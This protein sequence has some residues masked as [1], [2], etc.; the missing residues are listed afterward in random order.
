MELGLFPADRLGMPALGV[1]EHAGRSV[2]KPRLGC[3][4]RKRFR[5]A[6]GLPG[7][8]HQKLVTFP[9]KALCN[10]RYTPETNGMIW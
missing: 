10:M 9:R 6:S 1:D 8:Q 7:F 4:A 5:T 3:Y 2:Y